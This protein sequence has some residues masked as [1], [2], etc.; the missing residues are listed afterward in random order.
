ML[1]KIFSGALVGLDGV[2]VEV[3]VDIQGQEQAKRA[4]EIAAA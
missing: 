2:L 3:E 4:M 1:V